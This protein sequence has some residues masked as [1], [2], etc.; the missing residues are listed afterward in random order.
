MTP[1]LTSQGQGSLT[2][3]CS[4]PRAMAFCASLEGQVERNHSVITFVSGV[5][6]A[7]GQALDNG[8]RVIWS[9]FW[10]RGFQSV[11]LLASLW[12]LVK[13]E[14]QAPALAWIRD[15]RVGTK[16]V[17]ISPPGVHRHAKF[18]SA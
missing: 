12:E 7:L 9:I 6:Q 4:I 16:S 11:T 3:A 15:S 5:C 13:C 17:L 1:A 2:L 18:E 10:E 8:G 14:F